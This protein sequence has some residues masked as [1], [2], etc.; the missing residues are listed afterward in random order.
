MANF[1]IEVDALVELSK[2][3]R[4]RLDQ[5]VANC[6]VHHTFA[7]ATE[8]SLKVAG[9]VLAARTKAYAASIFPRS[10]FRIFA[11]TV[12]VCPERSRT[13]LN[14]TTSAPTIGAGS[15]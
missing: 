5:A 3:Q 15:A 4:N 6:L 7:P 12:A 1:V 2:D 14:S 13:G 10:S 11:A 8:I 9:L